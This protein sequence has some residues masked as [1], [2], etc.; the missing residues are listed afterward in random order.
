MIE[1]GLLL[2]FK[3][4]DNALSQHLAELDTPLVERVNI[5]DDALCE[6]GVF[7]KSNELDQRFRC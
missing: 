5:P 7:V 2:A 6:N 1:L 4:R 3:L